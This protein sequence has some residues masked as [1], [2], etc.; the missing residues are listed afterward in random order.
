MVADVGIGI[1]EHL[2]NFM[3]DIDSDGQAIIEA[4][5]PK[6]SGTFGSS[7]LYNQG[8]N[9][10]MGLYMSSNLAQNL[11]ADMYISSGNG[12]VHISPRDIT[13]ANLEYIWPGTIVFMRLKLKDNQSIDIEDVMEKIRTSAKDEISQRNKETTKAYKYFILS[14]YFG[15]YAEN[16]GEAIN[17]RD[18]YLMPTL[19]SGLSVKLDFTDIVVSPHSFLNALLANAVKELGESSFRRIKTVNATSEIND[20]VDYIFEDTLE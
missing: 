18:K 20:T 2:R 4:I 1:R 19:R 9:A 3:P 6:V 5:K 17:F 15:K 12:K 14:N 13:T 11:R 10:G 16:K 8:N 7:G